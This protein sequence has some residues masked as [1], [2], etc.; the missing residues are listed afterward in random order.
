MW[1]VEIGYFVLCD[2]ILVS[3]DVIQVQ[4]TSRQKRVRL[5]LSAGAQSRKI[6]GVLPLHFN[7]RLKHQFRK[8]VQVP[9]HLPGQ[10]RTRAE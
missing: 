10:L 3:G 5:A 2:C 7:W 4:V 9:D 8:L 6:T 1:P